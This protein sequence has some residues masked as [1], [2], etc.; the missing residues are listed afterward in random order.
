VTGTQ[1]VHRTPWLSIR[2]DK[3]V[4]PDKREAVWTVIEFR[5]AIGVVALTEDRQVH[6][7]GQH[8]YAVNRYEWELPEGLVDEGEDLLQAAKRE[9]REETG[10]IAR[11]WTPLGSTHPHNSS[12]DATYHIFL[13]EELE[14][15]PAS[16]EQTE[17]LARRLVPLAELMKMVQN[18]Q[19][20]DA[21]TIIGV[22]RAWHH[23][24]GIKG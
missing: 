18:D 14:Q 17:I 15:G 1:Q 21:F 7:V 11:Q 24:N 5:P 2:D 20:L 10:L 8:R 9:L 6:L 12:C 23:L 13:A 19:I 3:I 16:P 4:W 22:F